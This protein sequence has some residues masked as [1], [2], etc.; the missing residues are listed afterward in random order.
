MQMS[1]LGA[2]VLG[3]TIIIVLDFVPVIAAI[4]F[5]YWITH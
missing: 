1:K 5:T 4:A 3:L 2:A